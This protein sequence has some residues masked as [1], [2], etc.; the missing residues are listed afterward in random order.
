MPKAMKREKFFLF[1][2]ICFQMM[3]VNLTI[4]LDVVKETCVPHGKN[5]GQMQ[6]D[7][8]KETC[9]G[10]MKNAGHKFHRA[11]ISAFISS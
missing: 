8:V 1:S 2:N 10:H 5:A 11:P 3:G 6:I 4:K 7:V 9:V